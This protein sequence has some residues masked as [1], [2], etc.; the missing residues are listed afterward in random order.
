MEGYSNGVGKS[1]YASDELYQVDH[2]CDGGECLM[3]ASWFRCWIV[4]EW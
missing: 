2:V 3:E 1:C 4:V